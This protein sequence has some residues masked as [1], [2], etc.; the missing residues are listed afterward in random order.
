M[1][2][3]KLKSPVINGTFLMATDHPESYRM[4]YLVVPG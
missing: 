4:L 3:L 2:P 1:L